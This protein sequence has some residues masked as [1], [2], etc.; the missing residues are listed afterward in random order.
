[1][2]PD[3]HWTIRVMDVGGIQIDQI[4]N[5]LQKTIPAYANRT[6]VVPRHYQIIAS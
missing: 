5:K 6:T 1:M 3:I 2:N 4:R